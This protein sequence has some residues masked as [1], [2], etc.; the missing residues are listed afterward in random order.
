MGIF[1]WFK[2]KSKEEQEQIED[3]VEE[4]SK[5]VVSEKKNKEKMKGRHV[6]AMQLDDIAV[7]GSLVQAVYV[8]RYDAL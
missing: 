6:T 3:V 8:L 4:I 1:N 7:A 2:S 5:V